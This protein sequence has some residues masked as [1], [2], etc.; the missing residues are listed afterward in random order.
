[1]FVHKCY[2][3]G[4]LTRTQKIDTKL[5][6]QLTILALV[7]PV[8][9]ALSGWYFAFLI[10][11][12]DYPLLIAAACFAAGLLLDF[13]CYYGNIFSFVFYKTPIPLVLSV[14]GYELSSFF[15]S[16]RLSICTGIAGL[17]IGI[18]FDYVLLIDKPFYLA[19]K[20]LLVIVYMLL[21]FIL[22]GIMMGVPVSSFLL[23]ILAGNYY[24]LRYEGAVMSKERL[25]RNLLNISL[26]TTLVLLFLELIFGWLI[27]QD[28]VNIIDY[29]HHMTDWQLSRNHLLILIFG[30]GVLAVVVQYLITYYT[31]KIM[32]HYRKIKYRNAIS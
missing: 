30:F 18:V 11:E 25:R 16:Q 28:A 13:I 17:F 2:F 8:A 29:L 6:I 10:I 20:R 22:L 31:G 1:M 27:W 9:G 26:F 15:L 19:R 7:M 14:M 32:L 21:S 23:G 24:S 3:S 12:S 4:M 5:W